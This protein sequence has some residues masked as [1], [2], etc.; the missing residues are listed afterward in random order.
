MHPLLSDP[1]M[2]IDQ[3]SE[4]VRKALAAKAPFDELHSILVQYK[5]D[6]GGQQE[7]LAALQA[8]RASLD[9]ET[10]DLVLEMMECASGWCSP[11]ARIWD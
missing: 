10:E 8:M 4:V 1:A 3:F 11:H 2:T 9:D 6:G 7:A 5:A